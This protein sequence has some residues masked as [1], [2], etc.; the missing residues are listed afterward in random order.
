M[1]VYNKHNA[2]LVNIDK[3]Y[4]LLISKHYPYGE[5]VY[6]I[7]A[8]FLDGQEF[9]G[10]GGIEIAEYASIKNVEKDMD[11]IFDA[12]NRR[13]NVYLLQHNAC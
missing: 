10:M 12:M 1:W 7:M 8:C 2:R 11:G 4:T 9:N 13:S 6:N 5:T 3:S